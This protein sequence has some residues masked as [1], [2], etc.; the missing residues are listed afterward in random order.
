MWPSR[1]D[2][3]TGC[4]SIPTLPIHDSGH[5]PAGLMIAGTAMSDQRVLAIGLAVEA[6]LR[7]A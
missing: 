4:G 1:R 7:S 2:V 3:A 5:A 6:H